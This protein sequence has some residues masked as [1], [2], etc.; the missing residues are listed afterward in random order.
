[1]I[2]KAVFFSVIFFELFKSRSKSFHYK[3]RTALAINQKM[4]LVDNLNG[5]SCP[6]CPTCPPCVGATGFPEPYDSLIQGV[7]YLIFSGF[8]TALFYWEK[9]KNLISYCF[10]LYRRRQ[11][12]RRLETFHLEG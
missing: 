8:P 2:A 1:L 4:N 10:R 11:Q 3:K 12:E 9:A 7:G 5:P 6:A